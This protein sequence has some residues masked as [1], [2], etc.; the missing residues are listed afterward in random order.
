MYKE[1]LS[2]NYKRT[3][4]LVLSERNTKARRRFTRE[5]EGGRRTSKRGTLD[6]RGSSGFGFVQSAGDAS[7]ET[8]CHGSGDIEAK[9]LSSPTSGV[10]GMVRAVHQERGETEEGNERKVL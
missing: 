10:G 4:L 8:G 7:A 2:A 3:S 5:E 6:S 1:H 9:E